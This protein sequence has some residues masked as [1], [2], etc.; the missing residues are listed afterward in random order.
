MT[1]DRGTMIDAMVDML[2]SEIAP[3]QHDDHLLAMMAAS[4]HESVIGGLHVLE[5]DLDPRTAQA[6]EAAIQYTR[7]LAQR[8]I[9]LSALLRAFRLGH[10]AFVEM[11]LAE[12]AAD[13]ETSTADAAAAGVVAMRAST[14]YVD[15]VS[16]QL[17]LAYERERESWTQHHSMLRAGM[18]KSLL[19]GDDL[20]LAATEAAL[21]YRLGQTHLGLLLWFDREVG[22][23]G[24]GL[25]TLEKLATRI[26][27]ALDGL[28]LSVPADADSVQVWVG[29]PGP[30]CEDTVARS[31]NAML[32]AT[33]DPRPRAAIGRP[34]AGI[35]GFRSSHRQARAARQVAVAAGRR[36][37]PVTDYAEV[38]AIALLCTDLAA[39]RTWVLDT[40]GGLATDDDTTE[41]L[42]ET[43]RVF[44]H[45]GSSHTA[46]AERLNLHKN[47]VVYRISRA[48]AARGRPLRS[49]RADVELALRAAHLLGPVVLAQQT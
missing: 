30:E 4:T 9:P 1:A 40:L 12:I 43:V 38:G 17:V 46:A 23:P 10:A 7:R 34:A 42:R 20:D 2:A 18:I 48:E 24:E 6:G 15:T 39:T 45:L 44:L 21:G 5:N 16:E 19:D 36:C 13:P 32:D 33:P 35:A 8:A 14:G 26:A 37:G 47:S 49:D 11:L 41:R 31:V 28:H 22:A 29:L 27:A 25:L 3:L